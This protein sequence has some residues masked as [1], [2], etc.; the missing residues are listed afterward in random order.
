MA[1]Y[2]LEK[3]TRSSWMEIDLDYLAHNYKEIR[4]TL[5]EETE[6]MAAASK[7]C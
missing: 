7:I 3:L 1:V 5:K 4:K 2:L 6:L